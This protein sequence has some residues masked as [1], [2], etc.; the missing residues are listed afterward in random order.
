MGTVTD[1]LRLLDPLLEQIHDETDLAI[2][3]QEIRGIEDYGFGIGDV[4]VV[5]IEGLNLDVVVGFDIGHVENG[6]GRGSGEDRK[7]RV[8]GYCSVVELTVAVCVGV[9]VRVVVVERDICHFKW[10]SERL[11]FP[12]F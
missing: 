4:V 1:Y 5:V 9:G 6:G 3:A 8:Q 12:F 7:I 2:A 10:K 11:V